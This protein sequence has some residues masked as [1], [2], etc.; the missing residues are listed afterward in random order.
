MGQTVEIHLL[1]LRILVVIA[2]ILIIAGCIFI[3]GSL[4][5]F[6]W[7]RAAGSGMLCV[8]LFFL[9]FLSESERRMTNVIRDKT[10]SP[11]EKL[12]PRN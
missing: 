11:P 3:F 2:V 4:L 9:Q 7:I 5:W 8:G 6:S 10:M 12:M 1:Y